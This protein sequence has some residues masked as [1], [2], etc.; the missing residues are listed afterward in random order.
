M[1]YAED[2]IGRSGVLKMMNV[3]EN[4]TEDARTCGII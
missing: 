4:G 1:I 3:N 2:T